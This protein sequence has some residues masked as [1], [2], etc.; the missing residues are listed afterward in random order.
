MKFM[1][2]PLDCGCDRSW[3]S[4]CR[5]RQAPLLTPAALGAGVI[6]A[7]GSLALAKRRSLCPGWLLA[8]ALLYLVPYVSLTSGWKLLK[9]SSHMS[10][11]LVN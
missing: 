6:G 8:P 10:T 1:E 7:H 11:L 4:H 3:L 5:L 9:C 2:T